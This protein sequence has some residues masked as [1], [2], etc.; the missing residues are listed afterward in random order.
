MTQERPARSLRRGGGPKYSRDWASADHLIEQESYEE[1]APPPP[2]ELPEGPQ[3]MQMVEELDTPEINPPQP[4]PVHGELPELNVIVPDVA[5]TKATEKKPEENKAVSKVRRSTIQ[6]ARRQTDIKAEEEERKKEAAAKAA[7]ERA[8]APVKAERKSTGKTAKLKSNLQDFEGQ[9]DKTKETVKE[10]S[11]AVTENI[12]TLSENITDTVVTGIQKVSKK[13]NAFISGFGKKKPK[14]SDAEAFDD[15]DFDDDDFDDAPIP[16]E[17]HSSTSAPPP[18]TPPREK[19][20]A[21]KEAAPKKEA[22]PLDNVP[23]I[24]SIYYADLLKEKVHFHSFDK[25][26]LVE[27]P[28]SLDRDELQKQFVNNALDDIRKCIKLVKDLP[29]AKE[30]PYAGVPLIYIFKNVREKDLLFFMH[31]VLSKPGPFR[32]KTFKISEAFATWILKRSASTSFSEPFPDVPPINYV[33]LYKDNLRFQTVERKQLVIAAGKSDK[34]VNE[35]FMENALNDIRNCIKMVEKFPA[36][37]EGPYKGQALRLIFKSV[38]KRDIYFFL[39]YV[40][41]QPE[42]FKGQNFKFSEAFASWILK[43]SHETELPK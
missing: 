16:A 5:P 39:H 40:K 37:T 4:R 22:S 34:E 6:R 27:E 2:P 42:I 32:K 35:T 17:G 18:G 28:E 7:A 26:P 43:R 15:E 23:K 36:P 30:G 33:P 10:T 1:A 9:I 14:A 31:Y 19:A 11:D 3:E 21:K 20:T 41:S 8:K 13:L 29:E 25:K 38:Q 12:K 24:P